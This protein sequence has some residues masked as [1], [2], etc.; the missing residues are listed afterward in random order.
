MTTFLYFL[1]LIVVASAS[2]P[3]NRGVW[4]WTWTG[5]NVAGLNNLNM[6]I[7]FSGW[8]NPDQ[9][10]GESN[11]IK[12][13]LPGRKFISL[14]GGNAN[15]AWTAADCSRVQSDCTSGGFAGYNGIAFDI[16]EGDNGLASPFAAAFRACKASGLV[17]L[18]TVSHSAPYGVGDAAT[19]MRSFFTNSDIDIISPQLYTS[20][21]ETGNDWATTAGVQWTEYAAFR[22]EVIPSIVTGTYWPDAES[23]FAKAGVRITGYIQWSQTVTLPPLSA[24]LGAPVPKTAPV[25]VPV[26]APVAVPKTSPVPVTGA[27]QWPSPVTT[28]KPVPVT[29]PKPVPV[30]VT[31]APQ[32]PSPK[33]VPV[34]SAPQWPSSPQPVPVTAPK[35]VPAPFSGRCPIN[36]CM[37]RYGYCGTG[38]SFCGAGCLS[39]PCTGSRPAPVSPP[40][41]NLCGGRCPQGMCCSK[42]GYCGSGPAY[43]STAARVDDTTEEQSPHVGALATPVFI[44]VIVCSIIGLVLLLGL[45][46]FFFR[47]LAD[48]PEHI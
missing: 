5:G 14:G 8:T 23:Q 27:P 40:T 9:A 20:G 19:L 24:P 2:D 36:Q 28:P 32:W 7:A 41:A 38:D 21:S 25:T 15:G 45:S 22:G 43:C 10:K 48:R 3:A 37:S 39:G 1:A 11:T 18:V 4:W 46:I 30:P 42:W 17:V 12:N 44:A 31:S 26:T 33:P 34:T 6:A 16:E 29:A 47:K 13:Q 35:S